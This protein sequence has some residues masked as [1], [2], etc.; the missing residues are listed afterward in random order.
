M[1]G[2]MGYISGAALIAVLAIIAFKIF[3]WWR[4]GSSKA[5]AMSP[6]QDMLFSLPTICDLQ[7]PLAEATH[8]PPQA[9]IVLR[10]D[11]WRQIEFVSEENREYIEQQ[12]VE[13]RRFRAE[14]RQGPFYTAILPRPEHPVE[15]SR[16]GVSQAALR[17]ALEIPTWEP[18]SIDWLGGA[19]EVQGGFAASLGH[20]VILYGYAIDNVVQQLGLLVPSHEPSIFCPA[21]VQKVAGFVKAD[22]VDWLKLARIASSDAPGFSNW[23]DTYRSL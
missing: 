18:L 2:I 5:I 1:T 9:E 20:G 15:F 22:L 21:T 7:P 11:D 12:F 10:E 4:R 8:Q 23:W 16:L 19:R 13:H 14:K 3:K 6:E 17:D